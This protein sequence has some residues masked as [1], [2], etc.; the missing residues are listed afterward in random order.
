MLQTEVTEV[1]GQRQLLKWTVPGLAHVFTFWGF[2]VLGLTIVE[3]YGA[4]VD[5]DFCIP[6]ARAAGP[7]SRSSR[8]CSRSP[9]WSASRSS[10]SSGCGRTRTRRAGSRAS[11]ARTLGAAWLVLFMIF[12]VVWTL[13]LYRGAQID[14]GD[15][16]YPT[17]WA[18]AS[19]WV[20]DLLDPLTDGLERSARRDRRAAAADRC[21]DRRSS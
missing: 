14:S 10:P 8:T 9:S 18:F 4:L 21:R 1:I 12:N 11:T 3:A 20:A 6:R 5:R 7:G 19:N 13:L 16:P 17:Q 15:F 2:L